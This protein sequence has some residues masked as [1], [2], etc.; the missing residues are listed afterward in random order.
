MS[1]TPPHPATVQIQVDWS[2][3]D[4]LPIMAVNMVLVQQTPHE[5]LLTFGAGVPPITAVPLTPE[6]AKGMKIVARPVA[7]V[8][9]SPGRLVELL[10]TLQQQLA[11]YQ[12]TQQH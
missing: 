6:Q 1:A 5:F 12:Q 9:L 11:L 10:Q 7:R 4:E 8:S 3:A 2:A